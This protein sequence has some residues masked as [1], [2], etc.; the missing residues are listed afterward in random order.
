MEKS[1]RK[2]WRNLWKILKKKFNNLYIKITIVSSMFFSKEILN[3]KK[4]LE[5]KGH[6]VSIPPNTEVCLEDSRTATSLEYCMKNNLLQ[7][8]FERI[9][10]HDAILVLNYEKSGIKGYIGGASLMEI[11]IAY[12]LGKKIFILNNLPDVRELR[13]VGEIL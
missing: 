13:Y 5:N 6:F 3:A 1:V 12:Y 4:Y 10:D 2:Q 7:K 8:C 11:G 9:R